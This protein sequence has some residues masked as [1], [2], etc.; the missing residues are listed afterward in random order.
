MEPFTQLAVRVLNHLIKGELWA[1]ERLRA[2]AGARILI[3]AGLPIRLQLD[4]CGLF[5]PGNAASDP[6]VSIT[7]PSDIVPRL[8]FER[9]KLFSSV[10][11]GG[12]ADIAESLAFVLRNLN[13]DVEADLAMVVGD[14]VAHRAVRIGRSLTDSLHQGIKR[15]TDNVVEYVAEESALLVSPVQVVEFGRAVNTLRDDL[16]R[17]EKR[18]SRL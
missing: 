7:L 13:W 18:I 4:D 1:Q 11:L 9:D 12:S 6:D 15:T 16:A 8:L 3:E 14:I 10:K 17:L 5:L 2:H